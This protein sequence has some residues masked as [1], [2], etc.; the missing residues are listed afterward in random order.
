[1]QR[2][3]VKVKSSSCWSEINLTWKRKELSPNR[4]GYNMLRKIKLHFTKSLP[5]MELILSLFSPKLQRVNNFIFRT[6]KN[7]GRVRENKKRKCSIESKSKIG[8]IKNLKSKQRTQT[9]T[10]KHKADDERAKLIRIE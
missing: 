8:A 6:V 5:K 10:T 4:R 9:C 1:M 3:I 7:N 2:S